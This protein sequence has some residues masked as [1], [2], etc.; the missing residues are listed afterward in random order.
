MISLLP[1]PQVEQPAGALS[2][3]I[4]EPPQVEQPTG[5][6]SQQL[7]AGAGSQQ[8]GAGSQQTGSGSQHDSSVTISQHVGA[9]SQHAFFLW[10]A[11]A[12]AVK[13]TSIATATQLNKVRFISI[14]QTK[15]S[16]TQ[17]IPLEIACRLTPHSAYSL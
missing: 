4:S 9:G 15:D 12:V 11:S 16:G 3:I 17:H 6:G 10:P 8:V 14:L 5:A 2:T 1:P 13:A 7:G